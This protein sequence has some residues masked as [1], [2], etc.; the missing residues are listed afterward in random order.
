V[1]WR[2]HPIPGDSPEVSYQ[3]GAQELYG[4]VMN[5]NEALEEG[6]AHQKESFDSGV[7]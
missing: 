4:G 7:A 1:G 2:R 3:G 6:F 5:S